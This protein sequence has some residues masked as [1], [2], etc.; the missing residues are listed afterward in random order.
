MKVGFYAS[1]AAALVV[2]LVARE[3]AGAAP[4]D[5]YV[6]YIQTDGS[7]KVVL[8]YVPCSN[9]V[10][11]VKVDVSSTTKNQCVFCA[12]GNANQ[13]NTYT[14]FLIPGTSGNYGWRF[15][16]KAN[17]SNYSKV[18]ASPG[19][20][21]VLKTTCE[22]LYVD[23]VRKTT[24]SIMNFTSD[25]KMALFF[26]YRAAVGAA[27]S[28]IVAGNNSG[29]EGTMKFYY[30]K[31]WDDNG[32]T[33]KF[34][35]K[36]YIDA[37]GVYCLKDDRSDEKIYS[38][39]SSD[40]FRGPVQYLDVDDDP[41][42]F[43][44]SAVYDTYGFRGNGSNGV[45]FI[46]N[47]TKR[48]SVPSACAL[49]DFASMSISG[50][51]VQMDADGMT[52]FPGD[53]SLETASLGVYRTSA[54]PTLL[55]AYCATNGT[56]RFGSGSTI[57]ISNDHTS[58]STKLYF[59]RLERSS[60]FGTLFFNCDNRN[61]SSPWG[62]SS[63]IGYVH[64]GRNCLFFADGFEDG[65]V[66]P[67]YMAAG[68][69]G[70]S[71]Q[72]KPW[73]F[74]QYS[75]VSGIVAAATH[76]GFDGATVG[77]IVELQA[78][79]TISSN[80]SAKRLVIAAN[81]LL[82]IEDGATL[83]LG[84]GTEPSG[85]IFDYCG[86]LA[87]G[88]SLDFGSSQGIFWTS[89]TNGAPTVRFGNV[90]IKGSNG[91]I[92][93]GRHNGSGH[94]TKYTL[95][96]TNAQWTGAA[97]FDESAFVLNDSTWTNLDYD[98]HIVGNSKC[99]ASFRHEPTSG[100]YEINGH[101]YFTGSGA[102]GAESTTFPSYYQNGKW[103]DKK[104]VSFKGGVTVSG[105]VVFNAVKTSNPSYRKTVFESAIDGDGSI[106]FQDS[107]A[108]SQVRNWYFSAANSYVGE[109]DVGTN[110]YLYVQ[111]SGTLGVGD[112]SISTNALVQ[113]SSRDGLAMGNV[114][115]GEGTLSLVSS[116]LI[117]SNSVAVGKF[118]LDADSSAVF[119]D[120]VSALYKMTLPS[121]A[122]V[123][124]LAGTTPSLTVPNGTV[125]AGT[126]RDID[127]SC[128]GIITNRGT[129]AV[130]R[131]GA[132]K[133]LDPIVINGD[134]VFEN[135]TFEISGIADAMGGTHTVLSVTGTVEGEPTFVFPE[136]KVYEITRA[137]NDWSFSKPA[138]FVLLVR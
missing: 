34:D 25:N 79:V 63:K 78:P 117:F 61:F 13:N 20:P 96:S 136:G 35:L 40:P 38:D 111:D 71:G 64:L 112:V 12:R 76:V 101:V 129:L 28:A 115:S 105:A 116:S 104:T 39:S 106:M 16:Y 99:G 21:V 80:V 54:T 58:R 26:S 27:D 70:Y 107:A 45:Q 57:G 97:V 29:N 133:R 89:L 113:F 53:I 95:M 134:A 91:M 120:D 51:A 92:F 5:R 68:I 3:C 47:T 138:G 126:L 73:C 83:S 55:S 7:Q 33:L 32:A 42:V 49:V 4:F 24:Y 103:S 122:A 135:T 132:N 50:G 1:C 94:I 85:V 98:V 48:F 130:T 84:N 23:G 88:G 74:L 69:F 8:D 110:N 14:L 19:T 124:A 123:S 6:D 119:G 114:F 75:S 60:A 127:I 22:G 93:A 137:G 15:D 125:F 56:V 90:A 65:E 100:T 2:A 52:L 17:V 41:L 108:D 128:D 62:A 59:G 102:D 46:G 131:V 10:V 77:D 87:G 37:D 81:H 30:M 31:I 43:S 44:S 36:P 72:N 86:T 121:G 67:A 11:E 82:T 18:S 66:L 9:T 109:T 118:T